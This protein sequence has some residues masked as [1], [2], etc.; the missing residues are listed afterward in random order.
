MKHK[1]YIALFCL[2]VF[3]V[4]LLSAVHA[5][6][7]GRTKLAT[8]EDVVMAFY[9][10]G[11]IIPDFGK[12]VKKRDPYINTP[13]ALRDK[14][15]DKE[16]LRLKSLYQNFDVEENF[17]AVGTKT[18][19]K[20][21]REKNSEDG[22]RYFLKAEF[23]AAPEAVYF[24]YDFMN[25]RIVL[26]PYG[27]EKFLHLEITRGDYDYIRRDKLTQK[28]GMTVFRMKAHE[29]DI[30][31]PYEIDGQAQW[32]LKTKIMAVEFWSKGGRLIFEYSR[33][34]FITPETMDLQ[35]LYTGQTPD[36]E[37]PLIQKGIVK[38]VPEFVKSKDK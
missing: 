9:K 26:M 6:A 31:Q 36:E 12:W 33:P 10:T 13:W 37:V 28:N 30:T 16:L 35:D 34:D 5:Q 2:T 25:E 32:V 38:P 4:A 7:Q 17:L 15:Y 29:A 14:V 23:K 1:A 18:K 3:G 8:T 21:T 19:F 22:Y 27:I 11:K 20:L 24:P